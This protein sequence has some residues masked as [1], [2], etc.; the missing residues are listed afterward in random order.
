MKILFVTNMYPNPDNRNPGP[1]VVS[2]A[3]SLRNQG[4]TVDVL[5]IAG[6][7]S[8]LNY[9]TAAYRVF[10]S[11]T[12][13][14]YD[15]VHAHYGLSG[16]PALFR[17]AAPLVVTLHGSDALS[18]RF[19][20][21]VS[22]I[23][24]RFADAVIAVSPNVASVIPGEV[25]P[26]GVD[27]DMFKPVPREEARTLLSL[28]PDKTLILFPF[29]PKRPEKRFDVA[30]STVR[31]LDSAGHPFELLVV[32]SVSHDR[33][34]LYYSAADALLLCSDSEGSPT[35]VKE[36]LAC[37]LPV[38]STDVGDVRQI[39]RGIAGT[40]VCAQD[41]DSL[42][43]GLVRVLA[44]RATNGFNGRPSMKRYDQNDIALAIAN[45]YRRVLDLHA[46]KRPHLGRAV[47]DPPSR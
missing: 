41:V 8:K 42:A 4:H 45:V 31:R 40:E 19:Q 33:M 23:V 35:S 24:C 34:R 46:R 44:Y 26:C 6:H 18:G 29:D 13:D 2:Q 16:V 28:P 25:I 14:R 17:R 37:N 15:I 3:T 43:Q 38:V 39:M 21:M 1:F 20:P 36:A 47:T 7:R 22:R 10:R 5:Y 32:S 11:T 27:L 9:V 12:L 30:Q